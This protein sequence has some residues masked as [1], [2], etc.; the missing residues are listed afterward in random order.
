MDLSQALEQM[1]AAGMVLSA[2]GD[3]LRVHTPSPLTE[4]QRAFIRD[5][6]AGL[7]RFV[8]GA[9]PPLTPLSDDERSAMKE[10][11]EERAAI[12]EYEGGEPRAR[13]ERKARGAMRVFRYRLTDAPDEWITLLSPGSTM[14]SARH[15]LVRRF[16]G[17]LLELVDDPSNLRTGSE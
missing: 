5:H 15:A 3:R 4:T 13:A 7:L 2:H 1:E 12:R 14:E 6:K 8:S 10:S 11:I 16:G 17:R 9:P